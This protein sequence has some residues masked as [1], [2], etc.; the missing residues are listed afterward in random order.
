VVSVAY[1]DT[2]ALLKRYVAE[3]G[4]RWVQTFLS[5]PEA[6]VVFTSRLTAV[7]ATCA[8]ARRMR[9]GALSPADHLKA[10]QAFDYDVSYRYILLDVAAAVLDA[11][12]LLAARY[13]LRA[14]DAVQLATGWLLDQELR[15]TDKPSLVF[16]S[17]DDRLLE[18]AQAEGLLTDNPNRHP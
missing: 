5:A 7:E 18:V 6:P 2:S 16:L 3:T 8:F 11:A 4:S 9:E 15:R 13:P 17:A 1:L 10:I 14:Y 12:R